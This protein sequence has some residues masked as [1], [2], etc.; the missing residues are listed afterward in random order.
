MWRGTTARRAV[1]V[2][3]CCQEDRAGRT[4]GLVYSG[5]SEEW[6]GMVVPQSSLGLPVLMTPS[7]IRWLLLGASLRTWV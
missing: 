7:A 3:G 5:P 6:L 1:A 2:S 4:G